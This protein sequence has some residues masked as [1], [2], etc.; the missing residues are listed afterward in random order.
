MA[1]KV[2]HQLWNFTLARLTGFEGLEIGAIQD[3]LSHG[4]TSVHD[5]GKIRENKK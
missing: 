3:F 5:I 1:E 2:G 4:I